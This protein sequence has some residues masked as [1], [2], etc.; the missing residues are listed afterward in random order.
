M[1]P[2]DTATLFTRMAAVSADML[3]GRRNILAEATAGPRILFTKKELTHWFGLPNAHRLNQAIDSLIA[4]GHVFNRRPSGA[5]EHLAFSWFDIQAIADELGH[6]PFIERNPACKGR[7]SVIMVQNPKGGVGKSVSV[8]HIGIGL[9]VANNQRYRV[10]IVD[11]DPQGT[12]GVYLRTQ[13]ET[14]RRLVDVLIDDVSPNKAEQRDAAR[15]LICQTQIPNLDVLPASTNDSMF[16]YWG[17]EKIS[18]AKSDDEKL[19]V[20]RRLYD[21][22]IAP[23]ADDYDIILI[24]SGPN[25]DLLTL[26]ILFAANSI[27][28]PLPAGIIELASIEAFFESLPKMYVKL[29][30]AGHRG[31]DFVRIFV[32]KFDR[33][34][35]SQAINAKDLT[36]NFGGIM[37]N[38][39]FEASQVITK[40]AATFDNVFECRQGEYAGDRSVFIRAKNN[41]SDL[42]DEVERLI[43][44][45]TF[46]CENGI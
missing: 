10:L 46:A 39:Q 16:N 34:D 25:L 32:S 7:P 45:H 15:T 5:I 18:D 41:I 4:K 37:L 22:V 21:A 8:A 31:M 20:Y 23:V 26:N 42:V 38:T 1:N 28:M 27:I 13:R 3:R 14:S 43:L 35:Q 17:I 44:T 9:A 40:L 24:D 36:I 6:K 33:T 19:S 30:K 12:Q 11:G 29:V 2:R